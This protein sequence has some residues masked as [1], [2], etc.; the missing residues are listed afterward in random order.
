MRNPVLWT[1]LLSAIVVIN[2]SS[3]SALPRHQGPPPP[4][5]P[6]A[7]YSP[8]TWARY[9]SEDGRFS[10]RF[11]GKPVASV[12]NPPSGVTAPPK[13]DFGFMG[14]LTYNV[15][16]V[17]FPVVLEQRVKIEE[18]LQGTKGA[19]LRSL[20]DPEGR[21]VAE[22]YVDVSGYKALYLQI[23]RGLKETFRF[24]IIPVG[25]RLYVVSVSGRRGNSNELEGADNFEK[26]A[27]AFFDS[28][29]VTD[30]PAAKPN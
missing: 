27:R 4:P 24:E 28:L 13:H 25:K 23:D 1:A 2:L 17:E 22:R 18:L 29:Q 26:I 7:D 11:P 9:N 19:M 30:T 6:A 8:G 5:P 14:V 12:E 3:L 10:A 21:I 20:A 15:S 16:Y